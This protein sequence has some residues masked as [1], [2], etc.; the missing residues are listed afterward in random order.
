MNRFVLSLLAVVFA[1]CAVFAS[2]GAALA[3]TA[4]IDRGGTHIGEDVWVNAGQVVDGDV[5]VVGGNATVEGTINGDM[6]VI[7]GTLDQRPGSRITG[8]TR[9]VGPSFGTPLPWGFGLGEGVRAGYNLLSA[10]LVL[11]FFLIFP[12]RTRMALDR[13]ERHP[14]LCAAIGLVGWIA[15]V[16]LAILLLVTL[17]LIPLIL[18]EAIVV[19]TA[20]FIGKAALSLLIGRRFYEMLSPTS[21]PAPLLALVLGLTL[22][23]AAELVPFLGHL[24]SAMVLL[25][26]LGATILAFVREDNFAGGPPFAPSRPPVS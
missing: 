26:G 4:T 24:V 1:A 12:V 22:V 25:F 17:I 10:V 2:T 19:M 20:V 3:H 23:T 15:V 16:P 14:G 5:T 7:G 18:V 11:V 6:T 8:E 21:T 13:L 9:V